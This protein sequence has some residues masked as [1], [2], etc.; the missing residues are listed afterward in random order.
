MLGYINPADSKSLLSAGFVYLYVC[1]FA[2]HFF[3]LSKA[4]DCCV[5]P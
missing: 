5:E 4:F 2:P 3:C 1:L